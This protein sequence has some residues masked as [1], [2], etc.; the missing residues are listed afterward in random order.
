MKRITVGLL[1]S[2]MVIFS[3]ILT[4][5]TSLQASSK[6]LKLYLTIDTDLNNQ[7]ISIATYQYGNKIYDHNGFM[8]TGVN[9]YTL[10]YPRHLVDNGQFEICIFT[11]NDG[12]YCGSGY[13]SEAKKPEHVFVNA[14]LGNNFG[15]IPDQDQSQSQL[16]LHRNAWMVFSYI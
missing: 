5:S 7:D 8:N 3:I 12:S 10:N 2:S 1:I 15:E 6:G 11:S 4:S 16:E 14:Y 13:N 9:E